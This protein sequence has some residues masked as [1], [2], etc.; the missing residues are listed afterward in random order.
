MRALKAAVIVMGVLIAAGVAVLAV[1]LVQRIGAV[2][3]APSAAALHAVIDEPEGTRIAAASLSGD[4]LVLQ[5]SGGGADRVVV[6]DLAHGRVAGR[7]AL[8][9]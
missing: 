9:H 2:A 6:F 3:V 5:L 7:V 1:T 8:A 4:R